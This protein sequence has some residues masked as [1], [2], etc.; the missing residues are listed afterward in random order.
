VGNIQEEVVIDPESTG[1]VHGRRQITFEQVV[2]IG[3][4][5]EPRGDCGTRVESSL[6]V[7]GGGIG[8]Q[9]GIALALRSTGKS[10]GFSPS[11]GV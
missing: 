3:Q 2:S 7:Y 6:R 4:N 11:E 1:G 5:S 8:R 9:R 10:R